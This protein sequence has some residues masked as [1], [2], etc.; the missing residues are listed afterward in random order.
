METSRLQ[1]HDCFVILASIRAEW[2]VHPASE[3]DEEVRVWALEKLGSFSERAT[4]SLARA[5]VTLG[6]D[7]DAIAAIEHLKD[8]VPSQEWLRSARSAK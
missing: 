2:R 5:M 4:F 6:I 7:A 3:F 8:D 1:P